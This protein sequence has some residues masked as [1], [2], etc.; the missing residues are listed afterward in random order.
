MKIH[1]SDQGGERPC[2]LSR[3]RAVHTASSCH[4]T[5]GVLTAPLQELR[6]ALYIPLLRTFVA[7]KICQGMT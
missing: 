3:A 5:S 6:T 7:A 2:H 1:S 4:I